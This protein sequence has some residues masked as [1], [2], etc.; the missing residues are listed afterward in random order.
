MRFSVCWSVLTGFFLAVLSAPASQL[1]IG[2]LVPVISAT[3]QHGQS[4]VS[5]NG[6]QF[7]L[8][9][10]EM[11]CAKSANQKL[12]EQGAGFLDRH[13][14]AYL[15]DIHTMP[16]IARFFAFPKMRKYPYRIILVD[17]AETLAAFPAH[18]GRVTVVTVS[19]GCRV[20]KISFW[21]PESEPM[22]VCFQ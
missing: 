22:T 5:T 8:I 10:T 19:P 17:K 4:F 3:D 9:A 15:L 12:A 1:A 16:G 18:S 7:I 14:A 13:H 11:A 2:D 21:D 20:E 6:F